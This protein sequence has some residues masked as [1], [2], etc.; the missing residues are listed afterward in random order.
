MS[1]SNGRPASTA[2]P[3]QGNGAY[4]HPQAGNPE[5]KAK[6]SSVITMIVQEKPKSTPRELPNELIQE[7]FAYTLLLPSPAPLDAWRMNTHTS[8]HGRFAR[9]LVLSRHWVPIVQA[10]MY[11]QNSFDCRKHGLGHDVGLHTYPGF[12]LVPRQPV[13]QHLR[14]LVIRILPISPAEIKGCRYTLS[15]A[16]WKTPGWSTLRRLTGAEGGFS[17]LEDLTLELTLYS[18][19]PKERRYRDRAKTSLQRVKGAGLT[20][21]ARKITMRAIR[22]EWEEILTFEAETVEWEAE[23][24]WADGGIQST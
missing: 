6:E 16:F 17:N 15:K 12:N 22:S 1:S 2:N 5:P 23:G 13:R 14:R 19:Y 3:I 18:K 10:L 4:P 7:I 24:A 8:P 21:K 9:F 11:R 20:I